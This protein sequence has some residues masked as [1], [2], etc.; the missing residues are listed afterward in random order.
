MGKIK[1]KKIM[2]S[3]VWSALINTFL[4]VTSTS[5]RLAIKIAKAHD[6][7]LNAAK[8]DPEIGAMYTAFHPLYINLNNAYTVWQ[9]QRGSQHGETV[10][11]ESSIATL[12][13]QKVAA[14]DVAA[15]VVYNKH[16][17][18]YAKLFP[19]NRTPFQNG[20]QNNRIAAVAALSGALTGIV[21][22]A[23]VKT[24]VD[25]FLSE[26]TSAQN[27]Q[28][29][30]LNS[31]L[32]QSGAVEDARVAVCVKMFG[33]YGRLVGKYE[34]SLMKVADFFPLKYLRQSH[35]I[36]FTRI[37]KP[38]VVHTI[39]KHTFATPDSV[40]VDI[41]SAATGRIFLSDT[42]DDKSLTKGVAFAANSHQ[43]FPIA[44]LGN[45][46]TATYLIIVNTD[47]NINLDY[48]VEL[49]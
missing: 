47:A 31:T 26:I 44:S 28:H 39:V 25:A 9:T 2:L 24:D 40:I 13:S 29:D 45:I 35:Q 12:S 8:A 32:M 18:D 19:N 33:N 11:F 7:A 20:S 3:T 22:L 16:S 4:S 27:T 43:I 6:V 34:E 30:A 1:N 48:D 21:P 14:W 38:G 49:A 17:S 37:I 42:K 41:N 36:F 5:Y 15:Q 46:A 23:A 10:A